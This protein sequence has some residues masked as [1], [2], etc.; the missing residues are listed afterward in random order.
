[1]INLSKNR[2]TSS[3]GVD[4]V[5]KLT[6]TAIV[7][8]P[9]ERVFSRLDDP[10]ALPFLYNCIADVSDVR[11]S[12]RHVGDTFRGTFSVVGLQFD[13]TFTR[14]EHAPPQK[15]AERFEGA[16]NG[17]MI[18]NL[19][20]QGSKTRVTLEASY[21]ISRG[22]FSRIVNKLLFQQVAEKNADRIL[23]NLAIL[24]EATEAKA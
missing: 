1:M 17:T 13:V 6:R 10:S 4:R 9:V 11:R 7:H 12:G 3:A 24:V 20:P 21:E 23:E 8:G 19:E 15:I 14:T 18:F 2:E 22:L 5:R 16:M